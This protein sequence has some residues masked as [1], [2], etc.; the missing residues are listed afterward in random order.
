[1]LGLVG[2]G[3]A[4]A[5]MHNTGQLCG[6]YLFVASSAAVWYQ[7][8]FMLVASLIFGAI[9]GL[10]S[11]SLVPLF[12][13]GTVIGINENN[14]FSEARILHRKSRLIAGMALLS[15][16]IALVFLKSPGALGI[17]AACA[18]LLALV[19]ARGRPGVL[20]YP[21]TSF[22]MLFLFVAIMYGFF[23]YGQSVSGLSFV[24]HEGIRETGLQWLR[25][26][27]WI[28]LSTVLTRLSFNRIVLVSA[29]RHSPLG[30]DTIAAA[31]FALELLPGL[32]ALVSRSTRLDLR[33]LIRQPKD[34][35]VWAI[36]TLYSDVVALVKAP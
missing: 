24:T 34:T 11:F 2:L 28:E 13:H 33:R 22:W 23:S 19:A 6:V 15:A 5:V 31:L 3:I 16:S 21:I 10:L 35:V 20:F 9:T 32:F 27:A 30:R 7:I 8:P 1:L 18:A 25:L 12:Y 17:A 26:F 14:G 29:L 4:G 36:K